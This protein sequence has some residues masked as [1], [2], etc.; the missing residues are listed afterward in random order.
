MHAH[1]GSK[2][3]MYTIGLCSR[4][5]VDGA[6]TVRKSCG[7]VAA[8]VAALQCRLKAYYEVYVCSWC[9]SSSVLTLTT[10]VCVGSMLST[11]ALL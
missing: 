2:Q 5:A 3:N 8:S 6:L 10:P 11:N 7:T 1:I 4:A 9:C